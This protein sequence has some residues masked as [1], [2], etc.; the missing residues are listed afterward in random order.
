MKRVLVTGATGF[1]GR[2]LCDVLKQRGYR[3]TAAVRRPVDLPAVDEV[4]PVGEL[5]G[6]TSWDSALRDID[7]VL[8]LAALAHRVGET[9]PYSAYEETNVHGTAALAEAVARS[10]TVKRMV[11]VSSIGAVCTLSAEMITEETACQ[12]ESD[13]GRS[14]RNAEVKV[15]E[16]LC[17]TE[18]DWCILR[19]TLVYGPENP[20]NMLR[21]LHLIRTGL[22]LPLGSVQ[23]RRNFVFVGNLV[24]ALERC[25][26]HPG[27]SRRIFHV[28][29]NE[30]FSTPE[31]LRL[32]GQEANRSLRL[33]PFPLI[34]IRALGK[35]GD[36]V[37]KI[38]GRS[39]GIDTYS[40]ER[41]VGS[42]V[43]DNSLLK[44]E[45][46]WSPPYTAETGFRL[47]L[48]PSTRS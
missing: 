38:S 4:I 29:D 35:A 24:D 30:V 40:V 47:T 10:A 25:L 5:S 26:T 37:R 3:V 17:E 43:V 32:L 42:L 7:Y 16:T 41:L 46:G 2:Y 23:N 44:K 22:P 36:L 19:P 27:A 21:L 6:R 14:K 20:G 9:V 48:N 12:P 39:V 8:H 28:S 15:R 11:F 18:A 1:I 33:V 31:L 45:V 13:Y 34:G